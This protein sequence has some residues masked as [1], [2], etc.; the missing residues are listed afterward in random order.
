L[1]AGPVADR[2]QEPDWLEACPELDLKNPE[3]LLESL[4]GQ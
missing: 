1:E 3:E 4:P 2:H